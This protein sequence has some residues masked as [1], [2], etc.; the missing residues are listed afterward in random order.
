MAGFEALLGCVAGAALAVALPSAAVA[1]GPGPKQDRASSQRIY[2]DA[3]EPGSGPRAP[4]N[5]GDVAMISLEKK[6]S[7]EAQAQ[8]NSAGE[9]K[10]DP[11]SAP[12]SPPAARPKN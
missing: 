12:F 7:P 5:G 1:Q 6:R 4:G 3:A 8:G 11:G 9:N 2:P 10:V